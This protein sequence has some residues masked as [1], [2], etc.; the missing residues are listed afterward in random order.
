MCCLRPK[1]GFWPATSRLHNW[2]WK[3]NNKTPWS[4]PTVDIA[5][6]SEYAS[7]SAGSSVSAFKA[8]GEV[9]THTASH[10]STYTDSHTLIWMREPVL[11]HGCSLVRQCFDVRGWD[12][13]LCGIIA[14]TVESVIKEQT[15][16]R[17][18]LL[19]FIYFSFTAHSSFLHSHIF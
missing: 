17:L 3:M 18:M 2:F 4:K 16:W 5:N 13:I 15:V 8:N 10:S 9:R 1:W 6:S 12:R 14:E 7:R 19:F 11:M